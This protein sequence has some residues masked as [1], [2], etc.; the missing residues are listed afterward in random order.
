VKCELECIVPGA[1]PIVTKPRSQKTPA[2]KATAPRRT[3]RA[4]G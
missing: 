2:V 3:A 4:K 1:E